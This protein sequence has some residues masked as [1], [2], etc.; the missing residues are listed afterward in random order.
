MHVRIG[1]RENDIEHDVDEGM[2]Q[3][4]PTLGTGTYCCY[5]VSDILFLLEALGAFC[6]VFCMTGKQRQ[7]RDK[8]PRNP[9]WTVVAS[10]DAQCSTSCLFC[11]QS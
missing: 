2:K 10:I 11:G 1:N 4:N 9:G 5:N 3:T 8:Y 7:D 6:C